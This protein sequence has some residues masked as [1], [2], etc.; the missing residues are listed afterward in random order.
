MKWKSKRINLGNVK[1]KSLSRFVFETNEELDITNIKPS[2]GDCTSAKLLKGSLHVQF[3]P[4]TIPVH[5]SRKQNYQDV[6]K[7]IIITYSDGEQD[8]LTFTAKIIKI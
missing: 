4:G 5:I 7:T 3:K 1:E 2:C 8:V 6:A